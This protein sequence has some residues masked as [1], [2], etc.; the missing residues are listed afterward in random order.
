MATPSVQAQAGSW[1]PGAKNTGPSAG[2]VAEVTKALRGEGPMP[3]FHAPAPEGPALVSQLRHFCDE[4][5]NPCAPGPARRIGDFL[6]AITVAVLRGASDTGV[7]C[8]KRPERRPCPGTIGAT[9]EADGIW[10]LCPE[11]GDRGRITHWEGTPW[12]RDAGG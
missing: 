12:V 9:R 6:G 5:G 7:R 2:V 10:W 4:H 8:R 1:G 11:C 3:E